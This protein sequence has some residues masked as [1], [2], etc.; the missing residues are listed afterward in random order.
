MVCH[1]PQNPAAGDVR[2]CGLPLMMKRTYQGDRAPASRTVETGCR[3]NVDAPV[4]PLA[5]RDTTA[6]GITG[7]SC[8]FSRTSNGRRAWLLHGATPDRTWGDDERWTRSRF[9]MLRSRWC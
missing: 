8:V 9:R 2:G 4:G 6:R 3:R 5:P 1:A 7:Y